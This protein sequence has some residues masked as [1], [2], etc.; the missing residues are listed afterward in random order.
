MGRPLALAYGAFSY[1]VFFGTFLYAIGFVGNL[2]VPK[3]ID[4]GT[5]GS[6]GQSLV[7]DALLLGLCG[8]A[9][10]NGAAKVQGV[11]DAF[12]P[13]PVERSTYVLLASL[14]PAGVNDFADAVAQR[15]RR[16]GYDPK[17][18]S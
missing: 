4:S 6:L 15:R 10:R 13:K 5:E 16:P 9:Q 7:I 11:V 18:R 14:P 1:M 17:K 12:V 8:P 3:S 2:V